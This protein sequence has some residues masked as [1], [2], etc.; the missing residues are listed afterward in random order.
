MVVQH[1]PSLLLRIE[2]VKVRLNKARACG[3]RCLSSKPFC[4]PSPLC[5]HLTEASAWW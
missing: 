2:G 3:H 1:L 5:E 4:G